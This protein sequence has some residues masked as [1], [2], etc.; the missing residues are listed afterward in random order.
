MSLSSDNLNPGY[1]AWKAWEGSKFGTFSKH[2]GILFSKELADASIKLTSESQVFEVGFGNGSFAGWVRKISNNY[3]GSETN[4][5][6]LDRATEWGMEAH[7]GTTDLASVASGRKFDLIAIFDVLE[8]LDVMDII[9]MLQSAR[10]CLSDGGIIII[11]VPSGDSPFSGPLQYG[12]ITHKTVL[13]SKAIVQLAIL[14]NLDVV[15][16]RGAA[17]PIFG[18]GLGVA[19][20]RLLVSMARFVAAKMINA[21]FHGNNATVISANLVATLR[22]KGSASCFR[23]PCKS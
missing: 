7:P 18:M 21:I 2:D 14:A 6:L 15:T 16:I 1:I 23:D 9:P 8:H 19:F 3:V 11:R 13:G 4:Q 12:D 20:K 22:A 17:Y 5:G 10:H